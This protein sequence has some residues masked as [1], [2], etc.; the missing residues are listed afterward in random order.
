MY[1]HGYSRTPTYNSWQSMIQRCFNSNNRAYK[2]YGARGITVHK[3]WLSF[4]KF[5]QDMGEKPEEYMD[6]ER[7]NNNESYY[8][9]N[10]KWTT[11]KENMQNRRSKGISQRK[12]E[13]LERRI[14]ERIKLINGI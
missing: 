13:R 5:L 3:R 6:L 2:Y 9:G 11:H 4:E 14:L 10:C 12:R 1:K 8:P 7:I